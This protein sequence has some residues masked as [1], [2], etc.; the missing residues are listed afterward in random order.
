MIDT[1]TNIKA[2]LYARYF[3]RKPHV[4]VFTELP[5]P[6][7]TVSHNDV[8]Y[9]FHGFFD[10]GIGLIRSGDEGAQTIY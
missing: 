3:I 4:A 2:E 7:T 6:K 8:S 10:Y 1:D 5:I 9:V